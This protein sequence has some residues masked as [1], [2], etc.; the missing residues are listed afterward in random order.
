MT[1]IFHNGQLRHGGDRKT[2]DAMTSI[3]PIVTLGSEALLI[4]YTPFHRIHDRD[5][6]LY[7][8]Y[9][10]AAVMW[11]HINGKFTMGKLK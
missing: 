1:Q 3:Q 4:A 11:L 9:A 6:K 10:G 7:T 8:P 5:H 2:F